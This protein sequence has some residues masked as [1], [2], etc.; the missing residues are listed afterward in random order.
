MFFLLHNLGQ[1]GPVFG[2]IA[3][4]MSVL[5]ADLMRSLYAIR[6]LAKMTGMP[7]ELT[8]TPG[9]GAPWTF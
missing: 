4:P 2:S 6:T 9:A 1:R 8:E 7:D 3:F 5:P